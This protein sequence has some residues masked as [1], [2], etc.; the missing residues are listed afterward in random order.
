MEDYLAQ[1]LYKIKRAHKVFIRNL[2]LEMMMGTDVANVRQRLLK[3]IVATEIYVRKTTIG[4]Y[5]L[6]YEFARQLML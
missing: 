4:M 2:N 6:H 5:L 3:H 1:A